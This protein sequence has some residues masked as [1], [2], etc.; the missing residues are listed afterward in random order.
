MK[1]DDQIAAFKADVDAKLSSISDSLGTMA[2]A[3]TNIAA[4]EKNILDQLKAIPSDGLS[5]ASQDA[6][7]SVVASLTTVADKSAAQA[8]ALNDLA[9]SIP[10]TTPTA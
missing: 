2:T 6:L 3:Q 7:A 5:Q 1:T 9:A 8:T 10:D 4:D